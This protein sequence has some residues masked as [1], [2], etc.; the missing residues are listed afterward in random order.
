MEQEDRRRNIATYTTVLRLSPDM[1]DFLHDFYRHVYTPMK[2]QYYITERLTYPE[3]DAFYRSLVEEP[4]P[5]LVSM[6]DFWQRYEYRCVNLDRIALDVRQRDRAHRSMSNNSHNNS[7]K[8]LSYSSSRSADPHR[9][10]PTA[11]HSP[12]MTTTS[13][14]SSSAGSTMKTLQQILDDARKH[15]E[16][17]RADTAAFQREQQEKEKPTLTMSL[18]DTT[19]TP[20]TA[21]TDAIEDDTAIVS[22][23][24]T[25]TKGEK[26]KRRLATKRTTRHLED[27]EGGV[28]AATATSTRV[29][30]ILEA[31]APRG[32]NV[33]L[34][35]EEA[36]IKT[37]TR[38]KDLEK[39]QKWKNRLANKRAVREISFKEAEDLPLVDDGSAKES[40]WQL[41]ETLTIANPFTLPPKEGKD[42]MV[43]LYVLD[44]SER[45]VGLHSALTE[46][47]G[48]HVMVA[49]SSPQVSKAASLGHL[50]AIKEDDREDST[51]I[52]RYAAVDW[53]NHLYDTVE[54]AQQSLT[55]QKEMYGK[56]LLERMDD[57]NPIM[58]SAQQDEQQE[59][60]MKRSKKSGSDHDDIV[61]M[62]RM[63][64]ITKGVDIL[65]NQAHKGYGSV[66]F[67]PDPH[68][69]PR[70]D[71]SSASRRDNAQHFIHDEA[72]TS[73][74][75]TRLIH[76]DDAT[77][78]GSDG[79]F[80]ST[81]MGSAALNES[82]EIL[83][84]LVAYF[85]ADQSLEIDGTYTS[86]LG[87]DN[88][89]LDTSC[90]NL[91]VDDE[92]PQNSP[93]TNIA[94]AIVDTVI[95]PKGP[96]ATVHSSA[97]VDDNTGSSEKCDCPSP[98]SIM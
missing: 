35:S 63:L 18:E 6:E 27:N 8:L 76:G 59:P 38:E 64:T 40:T 82:S 17:T 4:M 94:I 73:R 7:C 68:R 77:R 89:T 39:V 15:G 9:D 14:S 72:T 57:L 2:Q 55:Q 71:Q 66:T 62:A 49:T 16:A 58:P 48:D 53:G 24:S 84:T 12:S 34:V 33:P 10:E 98:C 69:E 86:I 13:T 5:P 19:G 22:R 20:S 30:S 78:D 85:N 74:W 21:N 50:P 96:A 52:P 46:T 95:S 60:T 47:S 61:S 56:A 70:Y 83:D 3:V 41:Q 25:S 26:W 29:N 79:S 80:H 23:A 90:L 42:D 65:S 97:Y 28:V 92:S 36:V 43:D 67:L 32:E 88:H 93:T 51:L 1:K 54:E 45:T 91:S 11:T 81:T 87:E 37:S 44:S 75:T 31:K